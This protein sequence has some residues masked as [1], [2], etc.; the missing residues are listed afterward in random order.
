MTGLE[1]ILIVSLFM[2]GVWHLI[3]ESAMK[4]LRTTGVEVC[5]DR[6]KLRRETYELRKVIAQLKL[7]HSQSESPEYRKLQKDI[8]DI[9]LMIELANSVT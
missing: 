3:T 4:V 6:D 9:E 1:I 8:S 2:L 7:E 5:D